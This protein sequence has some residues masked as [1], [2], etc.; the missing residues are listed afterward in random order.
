MF[1]HK[2]HQLFSHC[3]KSINTPNSCLLTN[4]LQFGELEYLLNFYCF[5]S[6]NIL[7]YVLPKKNILQCGGL[8]FGWSS[9]PPN[10]F[11]QS[12]QKALSEAIFENSWE[13]MQE[14]IETGKDREKRYTESWGSISQTRS[15]VIKLHLVIF[16]V[17]STTDNIHLWKGF[18]Y[19]CLEG[20]PKKKKL[21]KSTQFHPINQ[22]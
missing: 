3:V 14:E 15:T 17:F 6:M 5:Q 4:T 9:N 7:Q 11:H 21:K 18:K 16:L 1:K 22:V 19:P 2:H 13:K 8:E 20:K 10:L 12:T